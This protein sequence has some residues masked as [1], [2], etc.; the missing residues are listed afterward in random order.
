[1]MAGHVVAQQRIEVGA[2]YRFIV[3][4]GTYRVVTVNQCLSTPAAVKANAT[5]RIDVYCDYHNL[6]IVASSH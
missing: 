4:P 5:T 2:K 6:P 3:P 1:L